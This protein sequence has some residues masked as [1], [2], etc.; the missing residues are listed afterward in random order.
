MA[1]NVQYDMV[2]RVTSLFDLTFAE[3][4]LSLRAYTLAKNWSESK[5]KSMV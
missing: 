4:K 2:Q 1:H 3:R 5:S